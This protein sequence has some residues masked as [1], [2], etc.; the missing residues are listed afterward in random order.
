MF[1]HHLEHD[2]PTNARP[3][4]CGL[5]KPR[6]VLRS[7]GKK[8]SHQRFQLLRV[9]FAPSPRAAVSMCAE[10]GGCASELL[11]FAL[12]LRLIAFQSAFKTRYGYAARDTRGIRDCSRS[13]KMF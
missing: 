3:I 10:V 7:C 13:K 6:F 8:F 12:G 5:A 2:G 4:S 11:V 9:R 1:L